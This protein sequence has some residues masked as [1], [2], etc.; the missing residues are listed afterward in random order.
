M[1][2]DALRLPIPVS[3]DVL[4]GRGDSSDAVT[5]RVRVTVQ[6]PEALQAS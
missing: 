6:Q 5:A 4:F 2:E 3:P 1:P